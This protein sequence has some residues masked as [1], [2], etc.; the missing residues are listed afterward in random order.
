MSIIRRAPIGALALATV[1]VAA[2]CGS[3]NSSSSSGA[4]TTAGGAATTAASAATTAAASGATTTGAATTAAAAA[5]TTANANQTPIKI[6]VLLPLSGTFAT[7]Q[8]LDIINAQP[9][10]PGNDKI[11]GRPYQIISKDDQGNATAGAAAVHELLD[12]DKVDVIIGTNFTAVAN[13]ELPLTT[14]AKVL[15]LSLSGCPSCGDGATYPYAFS[16]EFDRP[17]Q[18]AATIPRIKALGLNEFAI[19][20]SQDASSK[21]YVDA[22]TAAAQ[23]GGMT[24]TKDVSFQPGNLDFGNQVQELKDSGTKLVYIASIAPA[25]EVN[26]VK[27]FDEADFHPIL[28]GNSS[29][30]VGT[31]AAATSNKDWVSTWQSSGYGLGEVNPVSSTV[32]KWRTNIKAA[33]GNDKYNQLAALGFNPV[34]AAQDWFTI[35]KAAVEANHTTD[36]P[37]LAKWIETNGYKGGLRADYTFTPQ[38]HNGFTANDVGWAQPGTIKDGF[39]DAAKTS[40]SS[41]GSTSTTSG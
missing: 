40:V 19:L 38:R 32:D 1:L 31:V 12:S 26:I 30:G 3:D 18:A 2:A 27:A 24:I 34:A 35:F 4:T 36:G 17:T 25:D 16:N 10:M 13:A 20:E 8:Y 7:P 9:K 29:M 14:A 6:G 15:Q 22:V 23:Q 41:G 33:L 5:A 39:L 21:P 28:M 37:T 11:D